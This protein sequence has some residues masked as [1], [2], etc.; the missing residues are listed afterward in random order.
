MNVKVFTSLNWLGD[1]GLTFHYSVP[2]LLS[3]LPHRTLVL[4]LQPPP[5]LHLPHSSPLSF[6]PLLSTTL[7]PSPPSPSDVISKSRSPWQQ[8]V[9]SSSP[10]LVF[11]GC[12]YFGRFV[13]CTRTSLARRQVTC[14]VEGGTML[15]SVGSVCLHTAAD[16]GKTSSVAVMT[17][18]KQSHAN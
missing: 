6:S 14:C 4:P 3:L 17:H 1:I 10:T 16:T 11:D 18:D 12:F 2:T 13:R 8:L 7:A 9:T 5:L 15:P